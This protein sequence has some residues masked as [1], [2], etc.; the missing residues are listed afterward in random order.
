MSTYFCAGCDKLCDKLLDPCSDPYDNNE[1]YCP[2]CTYEIEE[3]LTRGERHEPIRK[4]PPPHEHQD[5]N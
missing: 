5:G 4:N 2:E 1:L 3:E